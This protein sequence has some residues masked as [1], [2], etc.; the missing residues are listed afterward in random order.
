MVE[1]PEISLAMCENVYSNWIDGM[2]QGDMREQEKF[3]DY[4]LSR[5]KALLNYM[6]DFRDEI[7]YVIF[8]NPQRVEVIRIENI[9]YLLQLMPW[10]YAIY[11]MH[12][13][14]IASVHNISIPNSF[15]RG[16]ES[17]D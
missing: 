17:D 12:V 5:D 15:A 16:D 4:R 6:H 2:S 1:H 11:P 3:K 7:K 8:V 13:C 14:T 9:P 10:D